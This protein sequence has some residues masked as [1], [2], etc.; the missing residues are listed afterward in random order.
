MIPIIPKKV[1]LISF[2]LAIAICGFSQNVRGKKNSVFVELPGVSR[3][4]SLHYEG[5][6]YFQDNLGVA[7]GIGF[8]P[9]T[10]EYDYSLFFPI[11]LKLFYKMGNHMIEAGLEP[12]PYIWFDYYMGSNGRDKR[13]G[14]LDLVVAAQLA[15]NYSFFKDVFFVGA[16]FTPY[17]F[18][19]QYDLRYGQYVGNPYY[20]FGFQ[21]WGTLRMGCR[22]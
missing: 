13:K 16:A 15:Y 4:V 20:S 8:S 17:I 1:V 3:A 12:V 22:F 18:F 14:L 9:W 5:S 19:K 10:A 21:P 7:L 2:L 11:Q 6:I